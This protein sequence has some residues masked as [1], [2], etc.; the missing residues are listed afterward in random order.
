MLFVIF[1]VPESDGRIQR[2]SNGHISVVGVEIS[3]SDVGDMPLSAGHIADVWV[4]FREHNK[5]TAISVVY[6]SLR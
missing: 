3:G 2:R 6:F 4:A 1:E 5:L